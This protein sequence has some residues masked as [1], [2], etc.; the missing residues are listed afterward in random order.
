MANLTTE[1]SEE[2]LQRAVSQLRNNSQI[3]RFSAGSKARS[4]LGIMSSEIENLEDILSANMVL[5]LLNGA[6]GVYLD[7]L[8]DLVG[9]SREPAD[10]AAAKASS[11]IIKI[12]VPA[13][14]TA[15]LM[16][17]GSSI[18]IPG[19][20]IVQSS[21]G[22]FNY[23]TTGTVIM[24]AAETEV[25]VGARSTTFGTSGNLTAGTLSVLVYEGY[26]SYPAVTLIVSNVSA[27]ETGK[28]EETDDFFRFRISNALLVAEGANA[29]ALRFAALSTPSVTDVI[30]LELFRGIGTADLILDSTTGEISLT[31][32]RQVQDRIARTAAVGMNIAVRAPKLVGLEITIRPKYAI[33]TSAAEKSRANTAMRNAV[34]DLI[35]G[36]PIGGSL[37]VNTLAF[38]IIESDSSVIDIGLPNKPI[39]EIV[40]WRP[41][42]LSGRAPLLLQKNK[43]IE[44]KIDQRLTFEGS[45]TT[46]VQILS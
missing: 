6:S 42:Q 33:G 26:V 28:A 20:T 15:G 13:G 36:T 1:Q 14:Y 7:F 39:E 44:L 32:L 34:S 18:T 43:D 31:T 37:L 30:T 40:L 9:I 46:A 5:S 41:S 35:A 45:I 3:T 11:R 38:S 12:S 8:G 24:G 29:A 16:N 2:I 27:I 10:T 21:D 22:R 19:N 25:F 4:L 17:G 23:T